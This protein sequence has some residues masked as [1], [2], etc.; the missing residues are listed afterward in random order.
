MRIKILFALLAAACAVS[1]SELTIHVKPPKGDATA[2]MRNALKKASRH[3]GPVR[4]QLAPGVYDFHSGKADTLFYRV[5]NTASE[6]EWPTGMKHVG[7]LLK[8]QHDVTIAGDEG[9]KFVTHGEMTLWVVDSCRNITITGITVDAADPSVAEMTVT[10]RTDHTLV[11]RVNKDCRYEVRDG[12]LYWIGEGWEFTGGIAQ[13]HRPTSGTST[14][15]ESPLDR[16]K[17]VTEKEPG[18]L[19]FDYGEA[20]SPECVAGETYQ[21]RHSIR[22]EVGGL[23]NR[24][25]NVTLSDMHFAFIGNFGIVSQFATDVSFLRDRWVPLA[26]SGRTNV[27]FAD[28]LQMS[29]CRGLVRVEDCEFKGSHDDPINIHGTHQLIA[30]AGK[31]ELTV[32]Y[33]H[34][35][36][37][38][39]LG[40]TAGDTIDITDPQTLIPVARAVVAEAVMTDEYNTRLRLTEPLPAMLEAKGM[41]VEN[42]S[43][44]PAVVIARNKFSHTPT[45][46]ILVTTWRPVVIKDNLFTNIPMASILIADDGRSWYES[47]PVKNVTIEGNRF[48]DCVSPVIDITPECTKY[49]GYVHSGITIARNRFE[50]KSGAPAIRARSV[51]GLTVKDNSSNRPL[52]VM[53]TLCREAT[54]DEELPSVSE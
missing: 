15:C 45:R 36:T 39:F 41:V 19:E 47:G 52:T 38:G 34:S 14:R 26:E 40:F 53:V 50:S 22:N 30:D 35:Q 20:K 29:S 21:M 24:S 25:E 28:F 46:G 49:T 27:G 17:R 32:H 5:S 11:A 7:V 23:I 18:L 3:N 37:F 33:M 42:V 8:N 9:V 1:A 4:I 2:T 44:C 6:R 31:D 10:E 54:V 48:V 16:V 51:D 12:R 43:W 13:I